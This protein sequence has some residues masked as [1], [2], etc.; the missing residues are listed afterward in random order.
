M[1]PSTPEALS[2][3][4]GAVRKLITSDHI[5]VILGSFD[6]CRVPSRP[7]ASHAHVSPSLG[8][9]GQAPGAASHEMCGR[10]QAKHSEA[11]RY[12][13]RYATGWKQHWKEHWKLCKP[14]NSEKIRKHDTNTGT[15][16]NNPHNVEPSTWT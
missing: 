5:E 12:A 10:S 8:A 15:T 6:V 4:D 3:A 1:T 2:E 7:I 14:K 13:K 9:A 16:A 11:K